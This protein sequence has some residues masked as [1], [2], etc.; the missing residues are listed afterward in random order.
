VQALIPCFL[1]TLPDVSDKPTSFTVRT[2]E[3]RSERWRAAAR[4]FGYQSV[5]AWLYALAQEKVKEAGEELPE[6][7]LAWKKATFIVELRGSVPEQKG[8]KE[9][10]GL[11]AGPFGIYRGSSRSYGEPWV[12]SYTLTHLP[13]SFAYVSLKRCRDCKELARHLYRL[14]VRWQEADHDKITGPDYGEADRMV[15]WFREEFGI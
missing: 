10:S 9:V 2:T 11:I 3:E 8:L 5:T 6:K 15:K 13:S 1:R 14:R 12:H 4:Y 7:S